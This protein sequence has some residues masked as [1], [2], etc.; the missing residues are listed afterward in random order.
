MLFLLQ[1]VGGEGGERRRRLPLFLLQHQYSTTGKA[2][3]HSVMIMFM[4]MMMMTMVIQ[5]EYTHTRQYND[6][7]ADDDETQDHI[8]MIYKH[9]V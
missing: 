3:I 8:K 2:L 9:F 4:M 5:S 1:L 7:D 6:D